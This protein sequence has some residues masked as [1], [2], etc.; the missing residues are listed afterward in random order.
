MSDVAAEYR[1]LRTH[2]VVYD[3]GNRAL[4]RTTGPDRVAFL[5]GML[6]N[7]VASLRP[8]DG[9]AALLLTIQGRVVADLRVAATDD[10]L[11]LDVE[12]EARDAMLEALGR[13]V[14]A[15]DVELVPDDDVTLVG[16][17]GPAVPRLVPVVGALPPLGHAVVSV[18]DVP[19][20]IVHASAVGDDGAVVHVAVGDAARVRDALAAS[21][22]IVCRPAA[23]EARRIECGIPR[24][25]VDMNEKTL[26]LEVPVEGAISTTKGCYLGQEVIARGTARGHVNRRLRGLVFAGA[27][28]PPGAALVR[29]GHEVGQ[30]TSVAHSPAL[31]CP[32]GLGFLRREH[33]DVGTTLDV[34]GASAP[35]TARVAAWPLA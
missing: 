19:V 6:T 35:A 29:D 15:D 9:C 13:L 18:A 7:D 5:Q 12:R 26:A 14:I 30:V 20:R 24:L 16:V 33:W 17:T 34:V 31:G 3:L 32:V 21:G 10:A 27:P 11:L 4:V 2:A 23:L 25:G 28:P 1:A 8:G 22:A